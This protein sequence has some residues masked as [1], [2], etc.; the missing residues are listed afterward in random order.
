[1]ALKELGLLVPLALGGMW[2]TGVFGGGYSR[3]VDRPP[4]Q[5]LAALQDLNVS[6][7]PGSPGTDPSRSGGVQPV[8]VT[9]RT[10]DGISFVVMS[11]DRVAIRMTAH[12]QPLEGGTRTRVTASVQRGDAPDDFVSPAFRSEGVTLGLF[13]SALEDELNELVAP[14]AASAEH[15]REL[16]ERLLAQNAG[17][18]AAG[19]PDNAADAIRQ[20]ARTAIG[21][22][23]IEGELR[24]NGCDTSSPGFQGVSNQ[25]GSPMSSSGGSSPP[26]GVSFEAGRPMV[27][28]NRSGR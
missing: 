26:P 22:H 23:G 24:R 19:R 25:M 5:V 4:A 21:L 28:L 1:M 3:D 9:E 20:T 18:L 13:S 10:A 27:D 14:P 11:G 2:V 17:Q 16:M 6:E 8:F 12:L 7:Q 15:C